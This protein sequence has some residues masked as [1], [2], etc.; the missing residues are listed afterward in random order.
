MVQRKIRPIHRPYSGA[1]NSLCNMKMTITSIVVGILRTV[2][3]NL[4][5]SVGWLVWLVDYLIS[6]PLYTHILNIYL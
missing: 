5:C 3:K 6:N 2:S 1:E 4:G